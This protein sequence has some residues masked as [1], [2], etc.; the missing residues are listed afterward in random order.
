MIRP[1]RLSPGDP[2]AVVAPAGPVPRDRFEAGA[3]ILSARY[4]LVHEERVFARSGFLA[5]SDEERRSE[6]ARALADPSVKAVICARGGYGL[7][8]ILPS[9]DMEA[10][11][12]APKAIVGFSDITALHA[13]SAHAGV[14]G[15]HGPVVTQLGDLPEEDVRSLFELLES[16]RPPPPIGGLRVLAPGSATG[17]LLG[18]NLE[19]IS[20]LAGTPWQL[21]LRGA[22]LLL[23]EVGERPYRI[24]R[25]LTQLELAGGLDGLRG[26]ALGALE[27]CNE[28]PSSTV[29]SPT[30]EEVVVERLGRLGVPIVAGLPVGHGARNRALPLGTRV[31]IEGDSLRFEEAAVE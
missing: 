22:V 14:A 12:R 6:L 3:R 10:L 23:E 19:L 24:D 9:L 2:V 21:E 28:P 13:W 5:G 15:I 18:G 17:V 1:P 30:A 7:M 16:P 29:Q 26:V 4:R 20:R 11:R 25:A 27:K 8:R 31:T